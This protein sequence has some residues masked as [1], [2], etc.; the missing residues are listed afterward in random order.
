MPDAVGIGTDRRLKAP[1]VA[2]VTVS[3]SMA[4]ESTIGR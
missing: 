4:A 3:D 2:R 1:L